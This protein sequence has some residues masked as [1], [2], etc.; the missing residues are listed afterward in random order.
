MEQVQFESQFR[1]VGPDG[2]TLY[3]QANVVCN[4]FDATSSEA[5][6]TTQAGD[7]I[8]LDNVAATVIPRFE[9]VASGAAT[10]AD[11]PQTGLLKFLRTSAA[12]QLGLIGV[13][14]QDIPAGKSGVLAGSGSMLCVKSTGTVIAFGVDLQA[15]AGTANVEAAAAVLV[16]S[17]LGYSIKTNTV[18]APGTGST[19]QVGVLVNPH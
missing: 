3:A 5:S 7:C 6:N 11:I 14:V 8:R 13:P 16:G 15:A 17:N 2:V 4:P 10:P 9:R 12:D 1:L 19:F 18:A